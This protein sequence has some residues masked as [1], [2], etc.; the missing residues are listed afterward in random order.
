MII[1]VIPKEYAAVVGGGEVSGLIAPLVRGASLAVAADSGLEFMAS[2]GLTPDIVV[3]DFD[4]CDRSVA[5]EI[6]S[7][8]CRVFTLPREKDITDTEAALDIVL[9][10]GYRTVLV[11]GALGGN[12]I[13]HGIANFFLIETYA[14][15]GMDVILVSPRTSVTHV[16]GPGYAGISKRVFR[17][18]P[19]DWVSL[20]PVTESA[21][22]VVTGN[23]KF[24]LS[25]A[26]LKRGTTLG[27]SNEMLGEEAYVSAESGFLAV[28]LT[29]REPSSD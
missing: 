9:K 27:V 22:G 1:P 14:R 24:P 25:S 13:E 5:R 7:G 21:E 28:A 18:R 11:S 23:L 26:V 2:H 12:R 8:R 16:S 20:F 10:E 19:G 6:K 4:S 3:G 15:K 29:G 17:G